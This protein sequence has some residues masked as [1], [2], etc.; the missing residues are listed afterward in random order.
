MPD[1]TTDY[2]GLTLRGPIVASS[3]PH[4]EHLDDMKRLEE[5][6]VAALVLPSLFEEQLELESLDLDRFLSHGEESHA[7]ALSYLPDHGDFALG[8]TAYLD[9]ITA[10]KQALQ[11]PVIGSLN[12]IS[13]GGWTR[14]AKRMEEAGADALE[15]NVYYLPTDPEVSGSEVE[16]RYVNLV[17]EVSG[18]VKIPVAVKLTTFLSAPVH[19]ARRLG[20][21]GAKGLVLFNRLYQPDFDLEK[22][23]VVPSL[24]LSTPSTLRIRLRWTAII[25]GHTSA[26]IAISGGVHSGSDVLK[27]MMAGAKV[28]MVASS[29]LR[30][31]N[32]HVRVMLDELSR[33][34]EEHDYDSIRL[35][36]G[37]M[38]QRACA[39]PSAFERANY[40]RVLRSYALKGR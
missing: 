26:D 13:L 10:A 28:A 19:L 5:A 17:R 18:S 22:L 36:Q 4:T 12:G 30:H 21:A 1:L 25:W 39:D 37:S 35:M 7:E 14:Y 32:D 16:D 9:R 38:S 8:P 40:M 33:W 11:V 6:G 3:S 31:G 27:C 34:M 15:L 29:V 24:E 20:K 2:M 23:D